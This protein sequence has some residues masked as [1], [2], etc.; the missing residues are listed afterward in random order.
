MGGFIELA[1]SVIDALPA[2]EKSFTTGIGHTYDNIGRKGNAG[3][4]NHHIPVFIHTL[5]PKVCL[6]YFGGLL[7][8]HS[9]AAHQVLPKL[10]GGKVIEALRRGCRVADVGCGAA[11]PSLVL[12]AA[13]PTVDY[14]GFEISDVAIELSKE[15]Q[16]R[17]GVAN[18]RMHNVKTN[19]LAQESQ[20]NGK[21]DFVLTYDV[22]HDMA[23]PE[24]LAQEVKEAL[25]PGGTWLVVDIKNYGSIGENIRKLRLDAAVKYSIS[26][27]VCMSSALSEPD[28]LG[29]GTL[30]LSVDIATKMFTEAGLTKTRPFLVEGVENQFFEVTH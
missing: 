17:A 16:A 30:G 20:I 28:G 23:H 18:F 21:F 27:C 22:L 10:A 12:A 3:M 6:T 13:F 26:M 14:H 9:H 24:V 8:E 7:V 2:A 1:E 25:A 15:N 4:S 19:S 11:G 5:I 29:L